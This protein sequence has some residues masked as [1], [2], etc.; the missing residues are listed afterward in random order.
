MAVTP[1][2]LIAPTGA[3]S[4]DLLTALD[5][6]AGGA[7][8]VASAYLTAAVAKVAG[9]TDT[10]RQ[11]R[12][13]LAWATSQALTIRAQ[14]I[15]SGEMSASGD[16]EGSFSYS[17]AQAQELRK[18]ALTWITAYEVEA[19]AEQAATAPVVTT[20]PPATSRSV[21]VSFAW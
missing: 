16:R 4:S 12:A 18:A 11:N 3:L 1:T 5:P 13:A 10:G 20:P 7:E 14:Q 21:P 6:A 9:W 8:A 2:D 19:A 15:L 17:T